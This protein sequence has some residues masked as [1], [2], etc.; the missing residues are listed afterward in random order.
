[1]NILKLNA[2]PVDYI[3]DGGTL[4]N[5]FL[6]LSDDSTPSQLWVASLLE[7]ELPNGKNGLST[8]DVLDGN[9]VKTSLFKEIIDSDK[10]YYLGEEHAK[11]YGLSL[12]ILLKL[13]NSS[14]RLLV[15]AHPTKAQAQEFF[16][17]TIEGKTEAWYVLDTTED[18]NVYIGFKEFV[19]KEYFEELIEKQDTQKILD[20]LHCFSLEVGDI[21]V[22]PANTPHAMGG[23]SLIAEIQEPSPITLRAECIRPDGTK[24]PRESLHSGIGIQNMLTCF[25]FTTRTREETKET[26]FV[27]PTKIN[28]CENKIM[29]KNMED[30]FGMHQIFCHGSYKKEN[31]SF[32]VGLVLEGKGEII[33]EQG[34]GFYSLEKGEEFFIPNGVKKYEY[35][36]NLEI[37]ECYPPK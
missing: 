37:I 15:Q 24:M 27:S 8:V 31:D 17:P 14:D 10:N 7:E 26:F 21:I 1:M 4:I 30:F 18:A 9:T 33:V 35:T 20:C 22:V 16:G 36:G 6:N 11:K 25:D 32:V 12:G 23:G 3:I 19:T 2:N 13:L 28:D 5:E 34:H 29:P